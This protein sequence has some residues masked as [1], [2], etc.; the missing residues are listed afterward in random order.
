MSWTLCGGGGSG[1]DSG[2]VTVSGYA[3]GDSSQ[4]RTVCETEAFRFEINMSEGRL[5]SKNG[6]TTHVVWFRVGQIDGNGTFSTTGN[7]LITPLAVL[8]QQH[9]TL[10]VNGEQSGIITVVYRKFSEASLQCFV[11]MN[12][13]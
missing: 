7:G 9:Y 8:G 13:S 1:G 2:S 12:L 10:A 4:Y 5:V 3:L 6:V 11:S